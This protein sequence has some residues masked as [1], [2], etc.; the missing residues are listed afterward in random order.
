MKRY[1]D[2]LEK[3]ASP[4]PGYSNRTKPGLTFTP[5]ISSIPVASKTELL[6]DPLQIEIKILP[7][8]A[9]DD[10]IANFDYPENSGKNPEEAFNDLFAQTSK[11]F[12]EIRRLSLEAMKQGKNLTLKPEDYLNNVAQ[13][14]RLIEKLL[15]IN[16]EKCQIFED[17]INKLL[18][19]MENIF[20]K[21][22]PPP[23]PESS[24]LHRRTSSGARSSL[25]EAVSA[26]YFDLHALVEGNDPD[27]NN[28]DQ[29]NA[30][31]SAELPPA[32][33]NLTPA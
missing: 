13:L 29:D 7:L 8:Y 31:A 32:Q 17:L 21:N 10:F 20:T 14:S 25:S 2:R 23:S 26:S 4:V 19:E 24:S 5:S 16:A 22:S 6:L 27:Q 33:N 12:E 9:R 28:A 18:K 15:P 11:Q 30:K 1:L 3:P